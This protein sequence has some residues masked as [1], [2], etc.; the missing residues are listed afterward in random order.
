MKGCLIVS[1]IAISAQLN[2]QSNSNVPDNIRATNAIDALSS[3]NVSPGYM[4]YGISEASG[5]ITGSVYL[6]DNW[7]I[8]TLKL[9]GYGKELD[10]YQCK[11]NL[12][13]NQIEV[14]INNVIKA[15]DGGKVESLTW[16]DE[17]TS[18]K[19][20]YRNANVYKINDIYQEGF[21]EVDRKSVV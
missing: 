15:I 20:F 13:S 3:M 12:Y 21:L 7:K 17:N 6:S 4:L 5:E 1:A 18:V 16:S 14:K 2:A 9:M 10:N 8:T 11:V 19:K